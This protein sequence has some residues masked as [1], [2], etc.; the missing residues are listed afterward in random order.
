[1]A[2]HEQAPRDV[3]DLRNASAEAA[4]PAEPWGWFA[5]CQAFLA[6]PPDRKISRQ[7]MAHYRHIRDLPQP[8][9][10]DLDR[11]GAPLFVMRWIAWGIALGPAVR[12]KRYQAAVAFY[13]KADRWPPTRWLRAASVSADPDPEPAAAAAQLSSVAESRK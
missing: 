1:M 7:T 2:R 9:G 6:Q 13:K 5:Y 3:G 4:P 11:R 12:K 10:E 8:M